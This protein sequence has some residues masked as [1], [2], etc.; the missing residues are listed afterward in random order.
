MTAAPVNPEAS[1]HSHD[2]VRLEHVEMA[3]NGRP[4]LR[5]LTC[6]FPRGRISVVLGGSGSGKSTILKLIGG[7][8]H[9]RDGAVYVGERDIGRLSERALYEVR[10]ELGMMF[11]NGALLD[12]LSVFDNLA[13]PL[14]EHTRLSRDE[15]ERQVHERLQA[16]GL[17]DVD[18]LLPRE[19]SGGMVKRVA[20]ARALIQS[21]RV[22][23]V[24]EPFSG[25]DP[26]STKLIEA[27]LVRINRKYGMTMI[28]VSHHIPST[29]RM[30]DHVVLLLPGGPVQGSPEQLLA[31]ADPRVRRFLTEDTDAS[32]DVLAHAE[33]FE[34]GEHRPLLEQRRGRK[35]P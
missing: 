5:D 17:E 21:P 34:A 20:L 13:F 10:R 26:L 32:E 29:L 14:R 15:I 23:L 2:H 11:Q 25:L 4:V 27:L 30:A 28:V 9:A 18:D 22:L 12:S 8:I 3:Y 7:L 19:L 24:D 35:R 6:R 33:E 16:V 1:Q 31:S